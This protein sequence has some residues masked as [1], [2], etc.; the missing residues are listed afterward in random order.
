MA[1]PVPAAPRDCPKRRDVPAPKLTAATPLRDSADRRGVVIE[2]LQKDYLPTQ[3]ICADG[4]ATCDEWT[5]TEWDRYLL[6][7]R[8][9]TCLLRELDAIASMDEYPVSFA[10]L[11][12]SPLTRGVPPWGTPVG[13][14][15]AFGRAL[16][17]AEA[18][19]IA[20]HPYVIAIRAQDLS[21]DKP[22]EGCPLDTTAAIPQ[23]DC[24]T[25]REATTDKWSSAAETL[26][27]ARPDAGPHQVLVLISGGRKGCTVPRCAAEDRVSCPEL[28]EYTHYLEEWNWQSQQCVRASIAALG[29]E[30]TDERFWLV[31]TL[32]ANLTWEQIQMVGTHPHVLKIENNSGTSPP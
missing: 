4:Q 21:A 32:V 30:A 17:W 8:E 15:F 9:R 28:D 26:W 29:G 14:L 10:G 18:E 12:G 27:R 23:R 22:P 25:T 31:N 1:A 7:R 24:V 13:V 20:T 11:I 3:M 5:F 6:N 16:T 19:K 2:L